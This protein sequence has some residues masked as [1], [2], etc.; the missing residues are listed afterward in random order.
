MTAER[1]EWKS[2]YHFSTN[3]NS[4]NGDAILLSNSF[5]MLDTA[6]AAFVNLLGVVYLFLYC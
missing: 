2:L 3:V 4:V 5:V 1:R 6:K